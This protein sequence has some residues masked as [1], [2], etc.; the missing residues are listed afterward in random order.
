MGTPIYEL[1]PLLKVG[2]LYLDSLRLLFLGYTSPSTGSDPSVCE[3][4]QIEEVQPPP[5]QS[6]DK[7]LGQFD[8]RKCVCSRF[9]RPWDDGEDQGIQRSA[10]AYL[11]DSLVQEIA[12]D[13]LREYI[14]SH[15]HNSVGEPA[16]PFQQSTETRRGRII[17]YCLPFKML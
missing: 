10:D 11:R 8:P 4:L 5:T 2:E 12:F 1:F 7:F 14:Q 15:N 16:G 9:P 13:Y 6:F 17:S 3:M